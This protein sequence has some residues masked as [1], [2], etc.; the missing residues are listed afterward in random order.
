[1]NTRIDEIAPDLFRISTYIAKFDLQ[2]NQFLVRDDEPL[3]FHTGMK[4]MFSLVQKAVG[5]V[6]DPARV[7]WVGFS[8]FEA[9]ECGSLNEW[10][11]L[12]PRAVP[13][14]GIVGATVSINDFAD[15]RARVLADG[16]VLVTG[17]FR[18]HHL[19][20]PQVPHAW[21]A[22]LLFEET[23]GTLFCSDLCL[24]NGNLDPVNEEDILGPSRKAL[25]AFEAGPLAHSYPWTKL[26][27]PTLERLAELEPKLLAVMHGSCFTGDGGAVLRGL[28]GMM[29]EV[30]DPG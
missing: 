19:D 25:L 30:L 6:L 4:G 27:L 26:T 20:T 3:L 15:R 8:H 7:R 13:I 2:F 18:F 9:D 10:L 24:Q 23:G 16:E 21:D 14:C 1:M 5:K 11:A 29:E 12:A 17:R 22:A 28:A